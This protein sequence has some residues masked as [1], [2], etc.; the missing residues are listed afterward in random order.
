M[1][2]RATWLT[3]GAAPY[4]RAVVN[5]PV[6]YARLPA[7]TWAQATPSICGV[8]SRS[9]LTVGGVGAVGAVSARAGA[10]G[11]TARS[12]TAVAQSPEMRR[13]IDFPLTAA[14]L[15][16]MTHGPPDGRTSLVTILPRPPLSKP[17]RPIWWY[18]TARL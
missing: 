11:D 15:R 12:A 1:L 13:L 16:P 18:A 10:R 2:D 3:P 6:T 9:A 8:G 4:G 14:P 7:T 5:L 17:R